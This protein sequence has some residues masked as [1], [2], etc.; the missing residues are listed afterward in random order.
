MT[1]PSIANFSY[2]KKTQTKLC[3]LFLAV[4]H[5][6]DI[7]PMELQFTELMT[8]WG[9][10]FQNATIILRQ[11]KRKE[12]FTCNYRPL[13]TAQSLGTFETDCSSFVTSTS[14]RPPHLLSTLDLCTAL[15]HKFLLAITSPF[16]QE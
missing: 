16:N 15:A 2:P 12:R 4:S 8:T 9:V 3:T 13:T 10:F 7:S 6:P 5:E 11:K 1:I 14:N